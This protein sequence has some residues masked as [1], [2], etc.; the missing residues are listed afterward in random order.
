MIAYLIIPCINSNGNVNG[1]LYLHDDKV[2]NWNQDDINIG[3][4]VATEFSA[5]IERKQIEEA[6]K[7]KNE[8]LEAFNKLVIGRELRMIE[9]KK[10]VNE[11]LEKLGKEAKYKMVE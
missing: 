2:H 11:L 6:L 3:K 10:E 4:A 9:L 5:V 1:V 8:E 7:K